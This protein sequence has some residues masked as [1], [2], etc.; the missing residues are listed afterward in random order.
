MLRWSLAGR[1]AAALAV[2]AVLAAG[3]TAVAVRWLPPAAAALLSIAIMAPLA[4]W[5]AQRSA[6]PWI[7]VVRAVRDGIVSLHDRDFS[8]SIAATS[9]AELSALSKAYN[10]LGDVLRRERLDLYQ[11]E[12]L[13]DTVIQATPLALVLTDDGGRVI[14]SNFAARQLL[15]AGHKLEGLAFETVLENSPAP[16]REALAGTGDT[17]FTMEIAGEAQVYH[18]MQ[19]RFLLNARPHRL[20]LL[21]QLTRELAAQ[22]VAV[23]KKVIRV[24]AHELNNSLAPITSL[25]HSGRLLAQQPDEAQLERVFTTIAGRAA[26]LASFI[27]GYARFAKLPQPR[28]TLVS[29]E[30]FL[31]RLEGTA[32]FRIEGAVPQ[33]PASFDESQ[34]E[35]V[36]INLLKNAAESGSP[37]AEITV[38]VQAA[39]PG[40]RLE[41][42]DRGSGLSD[43][44]LRDALLPFYSTKPA[45]T[46]LGLTLCR[47]IIEAHGGTLSLA[48]RAGGGA[49]VTVWLP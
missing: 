40:F 44:T 33:E 5:L 34:L 46:G 28:P 2:T 25:A 12:L 4:V 43:G 20:V 42:G 35:Q 36:M 47:E 15:H 8:V 9:D 16:L 26:H 22:E 24:I 45:G 10:S 17:L 32:P 27:D 18:L 30:R 39:S 6:R 41:I 13:L 49:L 37:A 1:T 3:L 38:A 23:W 11:R 19:R 31:A 14:Y 29:W 21:K 7:Q 48:N